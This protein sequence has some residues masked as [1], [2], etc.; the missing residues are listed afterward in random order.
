MNTK[1]K[2]AGETDVNYDKV[3]IQLD[4]RTRVIEDKAGLQY[5]LQERT[6]AAVVNPT[7]GCYYSKAFS[8]RRAGV[9]LICKERGFALTAEQLVLFKV[10]LL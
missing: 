1:V 7:P 10:I 3:I 9:N 4:E 5:I 2:P 6:K 8:R